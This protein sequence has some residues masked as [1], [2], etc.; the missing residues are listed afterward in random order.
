MSKRGRRR[1]GVVV[2]AGGLALA[3]GCSL[4]TSY[5][6]FATGG[7][8]CGKRIPDRPSARKGPTGAE[9]LGAATAVHFLSSTDAGPLGYDLDKLCTC[10]DKRAC[11]NPKATDQQCDIPN[12]GIDNAAGQILAVL[13]PPQADNRLQD[14]LR[15]GKNGLIVRVHNWDGTPNDA[16]V[17]VSIYNVVGL[18]GDQEGGAPARLDGNDEFIVDEQGLLNP[19]DLGSRVFDTSAYVTNGVLVA[20][21]DFDFRLEVPN[22]LDAAS[23]SS[24]VQIPLTSARL[25][26]KIERVGP[27]GLRMADAQ[28]V[29]RLP[30]ERIFEQLP[31]I[32]LCRNNPAFAQIRGAT[33]AA[34]DLPVA[35]GQDGKNVACDALSFAIGLSVGPARL[36]GHAVSAGPS[37]PCGVE[38]AERCQ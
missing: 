36:G 30:V 19:Q 3:A 29:G 37:S 35:P 33:C 5:D 9:L 38:P 25:V 1:A 15:H 22:L 28:L 24:V 34:L 4:V 20:S 26:G 6:G 12:T 23:P 21:F 18:K 11:A 2:V 8:P 32:G 13:Y 27:N 17:K 14:S 10:P 31:S 16:D 7:V